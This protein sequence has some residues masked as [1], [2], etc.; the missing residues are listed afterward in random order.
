MDWKFLKP[1]IWNA[2]ITIIAGLLY[3][4]FAIGPTTY[5]C[6]LVADKVYTAY[7]DFF[8]YGKCGQTNSLIYSYASL[9]ATI[10]FVPAVYTI[11]SYIVY[12]LRNRRN[13]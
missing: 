6:A 12:F 11:A 3:L 4:F 7:A 1:N 13:T 9:L 8:G 5:M 10:L 2:I